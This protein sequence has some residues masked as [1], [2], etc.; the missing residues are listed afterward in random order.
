MRSIAR[1][2]FAVRQ[3]CANHYLR[4]YGTLRGKPRYGRLPRGVWYRRVQPPDAPEI[5]ILHLLAGKPVTRLICNDA[6]AMKIMSVE[7]GEKFR[8]ATAAR[9]KAG[10]LPENLDQMIRGFMPSAAFIAGM[11]HNAKDRAPLVVKALGTDQPSPWR[12]AP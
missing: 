2:R 3:R 9:E 10:L 7:Q 5:V 4:L 8:A 12:H 6:S 11:Q 1:Y